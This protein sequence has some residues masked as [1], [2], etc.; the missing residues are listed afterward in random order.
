MQFWSRTIFFINCLLVLTG[1]NLASVVFNVTD[2]AVNLSQ[3]KTKNSVCYLYAK[4]TMN[5][6]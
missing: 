1:D 6:S 3:R 5:Y 2:R 4:F